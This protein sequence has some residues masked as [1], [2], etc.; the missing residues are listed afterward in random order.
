MNELQKGIALNTRKITAYTAEISQE[1]SLFRPYEKVN[2][3]LWNLGHITMVRNTLIKIVSPSTKL[4]SYPSEVEL[5]GR[6]ATLQ[7][8]EAY[9]SLESITQYFI[10]RGEILI[11]LLGSASKEY[12]QQE[13]TFKIGPNPQ[14]NEELLYFLYNHETEHIGEIKVI[15]NIISRLK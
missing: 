1:E 10:K 3:L 8:N 7:N 5:F 4:E 15:K 11:E 9:P 12:L 2:C 13:A 14:T 6:G